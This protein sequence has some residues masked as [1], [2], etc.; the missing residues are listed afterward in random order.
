MWK[1]PSIPLGLR[2][3]GVGGEADLEVPRG[4]DG[5]RLR[6]GGGEELD[7][8]GRDNEVYRDGG[9]LWPLVE[10]AEKMSGLQEGAKK[11]LTVEMSQ[12]A[13]DWMKAAQ[14]CWSSK[15]VVLVRT[16]FKER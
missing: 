10:E 6:G 15:P 3:S 11:M 1:N 7:G 9:A 5:L 2:F 8:V 4:G 14:L 12:A 13:T 16:R